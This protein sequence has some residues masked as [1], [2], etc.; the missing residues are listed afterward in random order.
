[1]SGTLHRPP[2]RLSIK[3]HSVLEASQQLLL[4]K[5]ISESKHRPGMI[6]FVCVCVLVLNYPVVP[7]FKISAW[8]LS[9]PSGAG[10]R[11]PRSAGPQRLR[12]ILV[13][14]TFP[15]TLRL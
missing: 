3:H 6:S 11:P 1:M 10:T 9:G 13:G 7:S 15:L 12:P 5:T 8:A 14:S 2:D 4:S